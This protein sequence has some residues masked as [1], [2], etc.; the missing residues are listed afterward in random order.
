M[1]VLDIL[2]EAVIAGGDH[3]KRLQ[4]HIHS[5]AVENKD[6]SGRDI[7]TQA[8]HESQTAIISVFERRCP[9]VSIISEEKKNDSEDVRA[10]QKIVVDPLDGTKNFQRGSPLWSTTACYIEDGVL[11]AGV[12]YFPT[13]SKLVTAEKGKGC[14]INGGSHVLSYADPF[15]QSIVGMEW[16]YWLDDRQRRQ[17]LAVMDKAAGTHALLCATGSAVEVLEGITA[18]YVHPNPSDI[19][20]YI[21]DY[22]AGALALAEA[23]GCSIDDIACAPDGRPL[24][25]ANS[26]HMEAVLAASPALLKEVLDILRSVN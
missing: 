9:R 19:G 7:V 8:D 21:W 16:V 11:C 5:L 4:S 24:D 6:Q 1:N 10:P 3:A 25:W 22:A 2:I 13:L 14:R 18:A 17:L 20:G 12:I 15:H 26:V 23:I